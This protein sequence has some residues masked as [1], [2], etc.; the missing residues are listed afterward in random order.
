MSD[1]FGNKIMKGSYLLI[2]LFIEGEKTMKTA[3][4]TKALTVPLSK[5]IFQQIKEITDKQQIS[6]AEWVRV[7]CEKALNEMETSKGGKKND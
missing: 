2:H 3:L 6:M 5:E 4:F 7:A 1:P